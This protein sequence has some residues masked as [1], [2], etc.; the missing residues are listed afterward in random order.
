[1]HVL[2]F[3]CHHDMRE[4]AMTMSWFVPALVHNAV[5]RSPLV[6]RF[7][8]SFFLPAGLSLLSYACANWLLVRFYFRQDPSSAYV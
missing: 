4:C 2:H 8:F 6:S 3:V 5:L 1:M 7:L